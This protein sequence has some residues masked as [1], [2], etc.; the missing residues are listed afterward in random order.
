MFEVGKAI[1][2][3]ENEYLYLK[4]EINMR[5]SIRIIRLSEKED[6]HLRAE[7]CESEH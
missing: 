5:E 2:A 1:K 3:K 6:T 4:A 7:K